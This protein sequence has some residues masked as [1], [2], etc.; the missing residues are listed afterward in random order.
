MPRLKKQNRK[1]QSL[2]YSIIGII[3]GALVFRIKK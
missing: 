3:A 1:T 2:S